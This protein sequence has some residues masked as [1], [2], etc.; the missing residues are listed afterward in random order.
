MDETKETEETEV[1][2]QDDLLKELADKGY[3]VGLGAKRHL[4]SYDIIQ[5]VPGYISMVGLLIGV[6]QLAY[7]EPNYE[8]GISTI[9]IIASILAITIN[10]KPDKDSYRKTGVELTKT[11]NAYRVLY[12]K[13]K[14]SDPKDFTAEV[15]AMNDLFDKEETFKNRSEQLFGS[16]LWAHYKFFYSYMDIKWINEQKNFK[17]KDKC[18]NSLI[19]F[20]I[21]SVLLTFGFYLTFLKGDFSGI[22][23]IFNFYK[24]WLIIIILVLYELWIQI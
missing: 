9:L 1:L 19:W 8:K 24:K 17:F 12:E 22:I 18:P 23:D 5:I 3:R 21:I 15:K 6:C 16:D 14:R 7:P 2:K 4:A 10:S 11:F 20:F 13:V